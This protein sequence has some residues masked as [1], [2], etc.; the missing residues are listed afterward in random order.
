MNSFEIVVFSKDRAF[1]LQQYLR[2]FSRFC[3]VTN[4]SYHTTVLYRADP[5]SP[6][7]ASYDRVAAEFPSVSFIREM[8]G[9]GSFSFGTQLERILSDTQAAYILFGV[10]DV[11]HRHPSS[12]DHHSI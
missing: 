9:S 3:A 12:S 7:A 10:D 4:G 2:T 6:F 8:G 1:Q 5:G 11:S